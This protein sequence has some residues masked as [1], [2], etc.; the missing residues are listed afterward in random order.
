[1]NESEAKVLA[2]L[3]LATECTIDQVCARTGLGRRPM[4]A[5][6]GRLAYDGLVTDHVGAWSITPR[7]RSIMKAPVYQEIITEIRGVN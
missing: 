1:M 7:G 4:R 2:T 5:M 6:L 3:M